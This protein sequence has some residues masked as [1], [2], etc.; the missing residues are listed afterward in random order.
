MKRYLPWGL[1][2]GGFLTG[3]V[4]GTLILMFS[5]RGSAPPQGDAATPQDGGV[6]SPYVGAVSPDFRLPTLKGETVTLSE[7][8]GRPVVINFWASWCGPCQL[9][10]P[11]IQARATKWGDSLVVLGVNAGEPR[12]DVQSFADKLSL[13]F[14]ILL[15]ANNEAQRAYLV[16]GLPTTIVVGA[17]GIVQARHVGYMSGKQLDA[18]LTLVGLNP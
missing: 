16:Q 13:T 4:L 12:A 15:D 5:S 10:M 7:F 8:R 11:D 14:P 1:I 17:Q 9:E 2:L 6:V 3:I 18:Y